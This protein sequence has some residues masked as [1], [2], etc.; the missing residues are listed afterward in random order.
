ML[1]ILSC[2]SWSSVCLLW[3]NVYLGLLP[4]FLPGIFVVI[5]L[6]ELIVYFEK[7]ALILCIICKYFLPFCKLSF[8]F[9]YRFLCCAKGFPCGSA[10]KESACNAGDLGSISGLERSPGEEKDYPLQY[11]GLENSMVFI[12]HGVE[13]SRTLGVL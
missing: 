11:S 2:S 13:K 12:V 6:C 9:V 5:E 8:C 7:Q 10:G 4:L 3:R 1:S